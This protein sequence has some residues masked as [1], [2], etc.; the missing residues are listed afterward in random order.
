MALGSGAI[1]SSGI[2]ADSVLEN[3]ANLHKL[4]G[5]VRS[6]RS[7]VGAAIY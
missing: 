5:S 1:V 2:A 7:V 4:C 6:V 3:S